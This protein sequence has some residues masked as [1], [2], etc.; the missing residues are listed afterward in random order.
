[1]V[2]VGVRIVVVHLTSYPL[3]SKDRQGT[4]KC[5]MWYARYTPFQGG[6]CTAKSFVW[7]SGVP[8]VS[9][10]GCTALR[11]GEQK[12]INHGRVQ[13]RGTGTHTH[14]DS[15]WYRHFPCEG[16]HDRS[17]T[18]DIENKRCKLYLCPANQQ[19]VGCAAALRFED[20]GQT[21]TLNSKNPPN[22]VVPGTVETETPWW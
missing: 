20:T 5:S 8:L 14:G 3:T 10:G 6:C 19:G 2:I 22:L 21:S 4:L 18:C 13:D 1:M 16:Y 15:G 7:R 12:D 17:A 9:T 11:G